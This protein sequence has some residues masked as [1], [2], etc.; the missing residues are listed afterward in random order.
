VLNSLIGFFCCP[1]RPLPSFRRRF[2]PLVLLLPCGLSTMGRAADTV[3]HS[4]AT[5]RRMQIAP[6]GLSFEPNA[7]QGPTSARYLAQGRG[8]RVQLE[9]SRAVLEFQHSN[10]ESAK[11]PQGLPPDH[12]Q[13]PSLT[14]NFEGATEPLAI[15]GVDPLSTRKSYFPHSDP[16]TWVANVPTYAR[17][18]Y[19]QVYRGVDLAFYGNGDR[20]EYDFLLHPGA[21]PKPVRF[22][23]VGAENLHLDANGDLAAAIGG[24]EFTLL[25]PVAYQPAAGNAKRVFIE[26]GYRIER[27][28]TSSAQITFTLGDYDPSRPLVIDPV[29]VYG[30]YIPGNPSYTAT[31]N[32]E[33]YGSTAIRGMKADALGNTYVLAQIAGNGSAYNVMKY[34]PKGNLL[35]NVSVGSDDIQANVAAIAVDATGNIYVAGTANTGLVTTANAYEP[36][37]PTANA[38]I[39]F[40]TKIKSDAST[41]LYSTYLGGAEQ[42]ILGGLAV[43]QNG[44]AYLDGTSSGVDFPSTPGTYATSPLQQNQQFAFVAKIDTLLTGNASLVYSS[45]IN[46]NTAG[47]Q[48]AVS[49]IAVDAAGDAYFIANSPVGFPVTP[50]AYQFPGLE[51]GDAGAY[52]TELNPTATA[53]VYSA[54]LGP[55]TG[56]ALAVDGIGEVYATG[57]VNSAEF[58]TTPGA[59]QTSYA[60]GFAAKLSTGGSQLLYSTFLSGPSGYSGNNVSPEVIAIPSGCPS[61]CAVYVAGTTS[62]QDFP[63]VAPIQS[64]PGLQYGIL[65]NSSSGFLTELAANASFE[66]FSTYL[67]A[68]QSLTVSVTGLSVDSTGNIYFASN[69]AGA[70]APV[71]QPAGQGPGEGYLAKISPTAGGLALA[72]PAT[73]NFGTLLPIGLQTTYPV[74]LRNA[75]TTPITPTRPFVLSS[76]EFFET[77][78]CP[79]ILAAGAA[80]QINVTITPAAG[81]QR[82]GILTIAS[83]APNSPADVALSGTAVDEPAI[84]AS[85]YLINFPDTIQGYA[86]ASQVI[87]LTNY[88]DTAADIVPETGGLPDFAISNLCPAQL[89]AKASCTMTVAFAP[90]EIGLLS[91]SIFIPEPGYTYVYEFGYNYFDDYY[92]ADGITITLNGTGTL[93]PS[94]TGNGALSATALNFGSVLV[95]TFS[96]PFIA[97]LGTQSVTI[98]N[99]GTSPLT[100]LSATT[101]TAGQTGTSDFQVYQV[102]CEGYSCDAEFPQ[103]PIELLP[104]QS[105]SFTVTFNP[106]VSGP[107]TGTLT[108]GDSGPGGTQTVALAGVGLD[109]PPSLSINPAGM[110]FP[111]QPVGD[112]STAQTFLF[113]NTGDGVITID[114]ATTTNDFAI[115]PRNSVTNCEAT[116]LSSGAS[117]TLDVSFTPTAVGSRVGT[118]K[119]IDSLG[120]PQTFPLVGTG[121]VSTGAIVVS[122]SSLTFPAQATGSTSESQSFSL[123][124]PG[125]SSVTVNGIETTGDFSV[126]AISGSGYSDCN[127]TQVFPP[128]SGC[129]YFVTFTP[130]KSSGVETGSVIIRTTA[131]TQT[132]TLSGTAVASDTALELTP[133]AVNFNTVKIGTTAGTDNYFEGYTI[134]VQNTGTS[135]INMDNV[136]TITGI[137]PTPNSD[138]ALYGGG[139]DTDSCNTYILAPNFTG[140]PLPPGQFCQFSVTFTPSLSGAEKATFSLTDSAGT[141]TVTLTGIGAATYP[142]IVL[143]PATYTSIPSSVGIA[144]NNEYGVIIIENQ[145]VSTVTIS[146]VAVT[147]GSSDFS[148]SPYSGNCAIAIPAGNNCTIQVVFTP[149]VVG[150]RTGTL[151]VKDSGGD[152]YLGSLAGYGLVPRN[153]AAF[154]PG[155]LSFADQV[156]GNSYYLSSQTLSLANTGNTLIRVGQLTA[157]DVV[158]GTTTSGDFVTNYDGCSNEVVYP[159]S[160]CN[161]SIA[162]NPLSAATKTASITAPITYTDKSTASLTVA[163]TGTGIAPVNGATMVP[164]SAVFGNTTVG[165]TNPNSWNFTVTNTGN[166]AMTL[167]M[168]TTHNVSDPYVS[169][170]PG[171]FS[172]NDFGYY[173]NQLGPGQTETF[174][175]YFAPMTAG[176][177]TGSVAIPVAFASGKTG[178]LIANFSGTAIPPTQLVQVDPASS[179]FNAEV[180]GTLDTTNEL[181]YTVTNVGTG[182]VAMKSATVTSNFTIMGDTCSGK[183]ILL[184]N[185]YYYGPNYCQITV[186]FTPAASATPGYLRGTLTITDNAAGTTQTVALAGYALSVAQSLSLSQSTVSF[187]SLPINTSSASQVVYLTDRNPESNGTTNPRIQIDSIQ[188]GGTNPSDFLETENCGGNLGFTLA[189]RTVCEFTIVFAPNAGPLGARSATIT[190]TPAVGSPLVI[191]LT[192]KATA[193]ALVASITPEAISFP[194]QPVNSPGT[195]L[196]MQIKNITSRAISLGTIVSTNAN[197]FSVTADACSGTSLAPKSTCLISVVFTPASTGSRSGLI[198]VNSDAGELLNTAEL[199]GN[200]VN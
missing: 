143:S 54:F 146:S 82:S 184:L 107:E 196:S 176:L 89:A 52:V 14:M 13:N 114:R 38:Q 181:V 161:V 10:P 139:G 99:Q 32:G 185:G 154:S 83:D 87:T 151:T 116:T 118:M 175:I 152:T 193:A 124:D 81:G 26:A 130:T 192:G 125:N 105:A 5:A 24:E 41:V 183:T 76:S 35:F 166:E 127:L 22:T 91:E 78:N 170:S 158:L 1:V 188:L 194:T 189:G 145:S 75:G 109:S 36:T 195:A 177:R 159:G 97:S 65:Y 20:L 72:T 163:I 142:A 93:G 96:D 173:G 39:G 156:V 46:S 64:A 123:S 17:V 131:G 88:G 11:S 67:G 49:G 98:T 133:S 51:V 9:T 157:T 162:F 68:L 155:S 74:D 169:G 23:L 140:N 180:V 53:L 197:E 128:Y 150:Y 16:H 164:S 7:G 141:Q 34:D 112:A 3:Q 56:T 43:D 168:P 178:T 165:Q 48:Q 57:S 90:T 179:L 21:D 199:S 113:T 172:A 6:S 66:I 42:V 92:Y 63:L 174:S 104:E 37:A 149:S 101:T 73:L 171:D 8:Y 132:V 84:G 94:G 4:A 136:P 137:P 167:N 103:G 108:F 102:T 60:G 106:S 55:G 117:C 187:A 144:P 111:P 50:G 198:Q 153:D 19:R 2:L 191:Q 86:T 70:D 121:I 85:T 62:T 135:A 77:D 186:A 122:Q 110:A 25:K 30:L 129:T 33:Y 119:L 45:L 100:I 58:P 15:D 12:P 200:G 120:N 148:L 40:L 44:N 18:N 95:G 29:L 69:I 61:Y 115:V 160:S 138:F 28:S 147:A 126:S 47:G 27:S 190:I 59:F 71:T 80:C 79:A 182:P 134:V 31:G